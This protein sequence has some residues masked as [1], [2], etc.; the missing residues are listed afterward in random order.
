MSRQLRPQW[1]CSGSCTARSVNPIYYVTFTT[2]T[3]FASFLLFNGFN[4]S[5]PASAVS[6]LGGFVVIFMGV[7]LLN[8]N[9]CVF[10]SL[11][12]ALRTEAPLADAMLCR[13]VDP[14]TQ[15]PR[16]SLMTGEGI[17]GTGRLSESHD[18]FASRS[19][20]AYPPGSRRGGGGGGGYGA[21]HS[22]RDSSGSV[23]FNAYEEETVGLT[24]LNESEEED[25][26]GMDEERSSKRSHARAESEDLWRRNPHDVGTPMISTAPAAAPLPST[27][28]RAT[29]ATQGR[30][31]VNGVPA[32]AAQGTPNRPASV[33]SAAQVPRSP[34]DWRG[35][36]Y[37]AAPE[38]R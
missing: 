20:S 26:D 38:R 37:V 33:G 28:Q 6:L 27:G 30:N 21:P 13:L 7:Y 17:V 4:T 25:D 10:L 8:L 16:M 36:P 24:Q 23:L 22:R 19:R 1:W 12:M 5:G 29:P 9:R 35:V 3:I 15:Q 34:N 11:A 18:R 2:S 14:V 32:N 31:G